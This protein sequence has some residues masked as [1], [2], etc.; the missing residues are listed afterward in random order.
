VV[1]KIGEFSR[2]HRALASRIFFKGNE[3]WG[4][5]RKE[6]G[7]IR[8]MGW[9]G[10]STRNSDVSGIWGSELSGRIRLSRIADR[11]PIM[12]QE[13]WSRRSLLN[14]RKGEAYIIADLESLSF[15]S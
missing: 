2:G 7:D 13:G 5:K 12:Q 6:R 9:G 14:T 4:A 3:V 10:A 1:E 11:L 15:G 8:T